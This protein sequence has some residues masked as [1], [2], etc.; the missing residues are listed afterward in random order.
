[1]CVCY[2]VFVR[3]QSEFRCVDRI[4]CMR[5]LCEYFVTSARVLII[6]I[7]DICDTIVWARVICYVAIPC[8]STFIENFVWNLCKNEPNKILSA[9]H[10]INRRCRTT[11][12]E[13][14]WNASGD[15]SI[16]PR[17]YT[18]THGEKEFTWCIWRR[19]KWANYSYGK[20]GIGFSTAGGYEHSVSLGTERG[21]RK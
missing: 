7:R 21:R 5:I 13:C 18:N 1:M 10:G 2:R 4:T 11:D 20:R 16:S 12:L 14:D 3:D 15:R 9:R 6:R 8:V 19:G 17:E